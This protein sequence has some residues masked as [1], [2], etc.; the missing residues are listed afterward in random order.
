MSFAAGIRRMTKT[1]ATIGPASS[2]LPVLRGMVEAGVDVVR[3]NFS[4]GTHE[5]HAERIKL[6]R[7][8]SEEF[9]RPIALMQDLCGP[10]IR[11]GKHACGGPLAMPTGSKL[12][13]V[14]HN[15]LLGECPED[16][17]VVVGT[18]FEPLAKDVKPG[19]TILISDGNLNVRCTDVD[20]D[21]IHCEVVHGGM[22]KESQGLNVPN[23]DLSC[24]SITEKDIAD[25]E[26]AMEHDLDYVAV[27][28]VRSAADIEEVRGHMA[29]IG[30]SAPIIAKI[31]MPQAVTNLDEIIDTTDGVMVARGDLGV[32]LP[33]EEVPIQQK[34]IIAAANQKGIPVIVATQMLESMITAPRPTRAEVSDVTNAIFDGADACMLSAESAAGEFPVES[35]AMMAT[36]AEYAN[37][38]RDV[39]QTIV[40]QT[41]GITRNYSQSERVG[42]AASTLADDVG[43]KAIVCFTHSGKAARGITRH[44]PTC[45]VVAM[46][47]DG[48]TCRR[49]NLS[50]GVFPFTAGMMETAM[51]ATIVAEETVLGADIAK[52]GDRVVIT[53]G[54]PVTSTFQETNLIKIHEIGTIPDLPPEM[55]D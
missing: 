44:N 42:R 52:E 21:H 23:V 22:L 38:N 1:V 18:T 29:R 41:G 5:E 14:S 50:R 19:D 6:I 28:F 45:P 36:I 2:S 9:G 39:D 51:D 25:L 49:L 16:G 35:V 20:S 24:A 40:A 26:F 12:T 54:H 47:M 15:N 4:H 7:Q 46:T 11:T 17:R 31:E 8:V 3:L 37:L 10:K 30:K 48:P 53:S 32:E 33:P 13:I 55:M 34:R 27:S 43:A